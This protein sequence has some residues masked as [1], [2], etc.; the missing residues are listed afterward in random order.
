MLLATPAPGAANAASGATL[1]VRS[2]GRAVGSVDG[3]AH[4]PSA[5]APAGGT[6]LSRWSGV[7]EAILRPT[8]ELEIVYAQGRQG[9]DGAGEVDALAIEPVPGGP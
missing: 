2:D 5:H 3:V 4:A 8:S 7:G 1:I 6:T 9:E